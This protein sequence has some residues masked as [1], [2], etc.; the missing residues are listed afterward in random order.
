VS[1]RKI[2]IA[3]HTPKTPDYQRTQSTSAHSTPDSEKNS[4]ANSNSEEKVRKLE[5]YASS[6]SFDEEEIA[7]PR[8]TARR[9]R[10]NLGA[11]GRI[12]SYVK[13]RSER[14]IPK[15]PCQTNSID[16]DFNRSFSSASEDEGHPKTMTPEH[17]KETLKTSY[18]KESPVMVP[19]SPTKR[20]RPKQRDRAHPEDAALDL[21]IPSEQTSLYEF[22][23][24]CDWAS[25]HTELQLNPR[26]AK[27]VGKDGTTAL[28]LAVM[29]RA[30]PAMRDGHPDA[31]ASLELI[32]QLILAAPEAA[33]IRC[34]V[35]RYTPLCYACLVT[36]FDFEMDD[37]ADMI[38]LLMKHAPHSAFVFTDEGFSALDV[39]IISYSRLHQEKRE[40]YTSTGRTSTVVLRTLL[41]ENPSL[42][43]PRLYGNRIRGPVELL[44]RCNLHNFKEASG[45]EIVSC[46]KAIEK[47]KRNSH[48][49][50]ASSLSGF[51]AWKWTLILLKSTWKLHENEADEITPFMAVHAAAQLNGC[52]LAILSL[53]VD[54]FPQQVEKRSPLR[55][56]YNLP[57]HEVCNWATDDL[58]VCGD[59]VVHKRKAKAIE[60]L[61]HEFPKAARMSNNE[62]ATPLQLAIETCTP[63]DKGLEDLVHAFPKALVIPRS[64]ANY[65]DDSPLAKAVAFHEDDLGSV[66]SDEEEWAENALEACEGLY[67]FLIAGILSHVPERRYKSPT[68]DMNEDSKKEYERQLRDKD[69]ESLRAIYGLL[70]AKPEALALFVEDEKIRHALDDDDSSS[71][72]CIEY[73][74]DDEEEEDAT[75][76]FEH[77]IDSGDEYE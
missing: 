9:S 26:D 28:H 6:S 46:S 24:R 35:K 60:L 48:C 11:S 68:L 23:C 63:W 50:V 52:P 77:D 41:E 4:R 8:S 17:M 47:S 5:R 43:A 56:Q 69:L 13:K 19:Q 67:P 18:S 62:S 57:L 30:N 39:H 66:G 74:E 72:E 21:P 38:R 15:T 75:E 10:R 37:A 31:L 36:D 55:G 27:N 53:A 33:I 49:S 42:A 22:A 40:I 64:L 70:R 1:P 76:A 51:W 61:L 65:S 45:E 71:E 16:E 25:V 12:D 54:G 7:A 29:S 58:N 73:L 2:P 44:Y 20:R 14:I 34:K 59:S 32:E 3:P